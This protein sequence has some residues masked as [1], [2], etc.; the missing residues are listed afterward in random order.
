MWIR[1]FIWLMGNLNHVMLILG[2]VLL[3]GNILIM[4]RKLSPVMDQIVSVIFSKKFNK[5]GVEK[6]HRSV[7][8]II[9][10]GLDKALGD[11]PSTERFVTVTAGIIVGG[12]AVTMGH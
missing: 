12:A 4:W 6:K 8:E 7:D 1:N 10:N 11:D 5:D 2:T 3:A 9:W